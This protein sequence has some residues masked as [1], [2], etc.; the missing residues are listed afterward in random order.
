MRSEILKF[1]I[2]IVQKGQSG[3]WRNFESSLPCFSLAPQVKR[4]TITSQKF[5]LKFA[6]KFK[7]TLKMDKGS[8]AEI[9]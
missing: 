9:I 3:Y 7:F 6:L 8:R 1:L 5:A 4:V 2:S